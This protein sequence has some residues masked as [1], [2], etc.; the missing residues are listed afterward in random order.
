MRQTGEKG[1]V[2]LV[3]QAGLVGRVGQGGRGGLIGALAAAVIMMFA[4]RAPG[5]APWRQATANLPM[6]GY[7]I[8]RVY[9]HDKKAF[10]QGLQY[11]DGALYEGTG[12]GGESSIRKVEL[13]TGK[14]LQHRDVPPPHF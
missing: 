6:Y 11:V 12:R 3:G 4:S 14:V 13:A 10:T 7:Q 9:P 5:F 8:V 1:Q 2:G